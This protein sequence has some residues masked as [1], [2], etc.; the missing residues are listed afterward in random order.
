MNPLGSWVAFG[1]L[2][3]TTTLSLSVL[4]N[5]G[6]LL[7]RPLLRRSGAWVER[8]ASTAALVLPP[9]LGLSVV[10]ALGAQSALALADGTDHCLAHG[11]HLH[12]C[13]QHGR[14]WLEQAWALALVAA[15]ATFV[16]ARAVASVWSHTLAQRASA[17]LRTL[18]TA[19][20]ERC[21][22]VPSQER[23]AFTVGVFSPAVLLSSAA[24]EALGP[25]ERAAVVAH[26]LAHLEHGDL[27]RRVMLGFA[28]SF[29]APFLVEHTLR[30]W[31]L[32]AER[33]C[34]RRAAQVVGRP[35]VVASAMLELV[36]VT[37]SPLA[38]AGALFAAS[39][40]VPER[41][42]S[43]LSEEPGGERPARHLVRWA[44][45]AGVALTVACG[46]FAE[47]LHHLLETIL[48]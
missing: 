8:Q 13:L 30:L 16:T 3:F 14:A 44:A 33:I 10:V 38:P 20:G 47:P 45:A 6:V 31:A 22:L 18:G 4:L 26:E 39:G 40:D 21:Y 32:S 41:V 37:P 12:L 25:Q 46:V 9:L 35:S 24:W 36:R 1:L 34:D 43:V 42:R 48:G 23:F 7:A 11:H 19:L 17:T 27:W 28:A 5:A 2:F 15:A 29:G